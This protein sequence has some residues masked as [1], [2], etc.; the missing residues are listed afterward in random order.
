MAVLGPTTISVRSSRVRS[1]G[2]KAAD[3]TTTIAKIAMLVERLNARRRE[4]LTPATPAAPAA[5]EAAGDRDGDGP[6]VW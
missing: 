3:T 4:A 2:K 6:A 5:D 1:I